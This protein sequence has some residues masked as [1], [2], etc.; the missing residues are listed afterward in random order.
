MGIS[1]EFY[2]LLE[3]Y[4]SVRLQ[5]VFLNGQMSSSRPALAG[6]LQ[7]SILGLLLF[8]IY[9]NDLPNKLKSHA[10]LF[11]DDTSLLNYS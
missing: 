2:N 9:T 4:L 6:V 8:L 5:R 1:G 3:N 10:K 7:G 11:S